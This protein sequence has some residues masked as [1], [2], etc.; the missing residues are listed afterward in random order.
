MMI[1]KFGIIIFILIVEH[2]HCEENEEHVRVTQLNKNN[3]S[4]K[5]TNSGHYVLPNSNSSRQQYPAYEYPQMIGQC[6]GIYRNIQNLIE[7]PKFI[8]ARPICNL[9]C[10]YQIISPYVC[11][12]EFHVQFLEFSLH[13]SPNC[14][15]DRVIINYSDVL[16]G[17]IMGVKKY[18]TTGGVLNLT[19]SSV[20]W[21]SVGNGFKLLIT[22]LPC[23]DEMGRNKTA[24][25]GDKIEPII[26]ALSDEIGDD[27][28][29]DD[30]YNVNATYTVAD[31]SYDNQHPVYDVPTAYNI[32]S[33]VELNNRQDI[34]VEPLPPPIL[35]PPSIP[36]PIF[37]PIP[38]VTI[39]PTT[40]PQCCRNVYNQQR[41][42]MLSQGFPACSVLYNDCIYVIHKS[43]QNAC[44]LRIHF[45]YFLLD[46]VAQRQGQFGCINNFIEIDGQRICG[47]KTNFVYETQWG[48][49]PKVIRLRTIPGRYA[50]PQGF[51]FHVEQLDC[52]FKIQTSP[53]R[54]K[55]T[56][57]AKKLLLHP[58]LWKGLLI[59][60]HQ[61]HQNHPIKQ[62]YPQPQI[63]VD[64]EENFRGKFYQYQT[65]PSFIDSV[66]S[67]NYLKLIQLKIESFGILKHFCL[68]L[69]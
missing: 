12:N 47:C 50:Q 56:I 64:P 4:V 49:E 69:Y 17:K 13:P 54:Q 23:I 62:P 37:P 3:L 38:P 67:M 24:T 11:K 15:H 57:L 2:V 33:G 52:P 27:D 21:D 45:K 29:D 43:S 6:G 60:Q 25:S 61:Y 65:N 22:R 68:P 14:E 58:L 48:L 20:G 5:S 1:V 8:S 18:Q 53:S 35:P 7:S 26:P 42:L 32:S 34:P 19:F 66:C 39:P 28:D 40:L 51:I 44:R 55:R 16:C 41:F 59:G 46:D 30:L 31:P 63:E 9:R 36:P 10:E